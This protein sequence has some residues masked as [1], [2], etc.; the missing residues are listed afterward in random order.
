MT[1][2]DD[3]NKYP[4]IAAR[5]PFLPSDVKLISG[6][7]VIG[8]SSRHDVECTGCALTAVCAC[9]DASPR[10]KRRGPPTHDSSVRLRET[11]MIDRTTAIHHTEWARRRPDKNE[12]ARRR[13]TDRGWARRYSYPTSVQ[14]GSMEELSKRWNWTGVGNERKSFV[15]G[16]AGYSAS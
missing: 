10:S 9:S 16:C 12:Q 8:M 5:K 2:S 13:F 1:P 7:C 15:Q 6:D 3:Y 4:S 14:G 11:S